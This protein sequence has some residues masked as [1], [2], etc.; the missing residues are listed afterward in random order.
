[1]ALTLTRDAER[2]GDGTL[3]TAPQLYRL[4]RC[5]D[6]LAPPARY[7]LHGLDEVELGRGAAAP[8]RSAVARRLRVDVADGRMSGVHARLVREVGAW[9]VVDAGSKNGTFVNGQRVTSHALRD[10]DLLE[11]GHTFWLFRD[12]V[13]V[14]AD[15]PAVV[16]GGE[17]ARPAPGLATMLPALGYLF[18]DLARIARSV[19]PVLVLGESGTGKELVARAVHALSGRAGELIA[20][21][22]GAL[23]A[24]LV[25]AEL[26]GIRKGAYSGAVADRPG[27]FRA[28]D[29]GTLLLDEI[30]DL[31]LA[32]Q[33]ALLRVLQEREVRAVG[34]TRS[35]P[36]DVRVVAATH[37]DLAAAVAAGT[38]RA[39]L[40]ARLSGFVA[41]LPPLRERREDLG[42]LLADLLRRLAPA[43]A[44]GT[45][46]HFEAARELLSYRWPLNV[47]E[48]EKCL[49]SALALASDRIEL[50]H[51][52][53]A[54]RAAAA[55]AATATAPASVALVAPAS[56]AA[57][58][59]APPVGRTRDQLVA[60]LVEHGGNV[61]AVARA[62]GTS[63]S[64]LHRLAARLDVDLA[65]Y[66]R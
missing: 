15:E 63:R 50:A 35:V 51:L 37:H 10:G 11:L 62:L 12:A 57:A 38:F 49:E 45:V 25:E 13:P 59:A 29:G 31:E 52:P 6:L 4:L 46:L 7:R 3:V 48:L 30:G 20:V 22:C 2:R 55:A 18:D 9:L 39:D 19:A 23:P 16:H 5:D 66:R 8:G 47:R 21:N 53:V 64:Q 61:A 42:L 65:R 41:E 32:S 56:A 26:F 33:A 28:A 58:P 36:I 24:G 54:I 40:Y 27:L 14:R 44:A 17:L 34:D 60:L 43:R 1:P